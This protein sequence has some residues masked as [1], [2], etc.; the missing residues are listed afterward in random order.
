MLLTQR[1]GVS[2]RSH[3]HAFAQMAAHD[4][5]PTEL[6]ERFRGHCRMRNRIVQQYDEVRDDVFYAAGRQLVADAEDY[7]RH[8]ARVIEL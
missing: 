7:A 3:E 5:L 2:A 4:M 8:I 1:A 6:A